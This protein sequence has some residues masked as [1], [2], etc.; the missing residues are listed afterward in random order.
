VGSRKLDLDLVGVTEVK[1]FLNVSRQRVHQLIRDHP[2]FPAPVAELASGRIWL[3][4]DIEEWARRVGRLERG[5]AAE[6][7]ARGGGRRL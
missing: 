4:K 1:E 7:R 2:D 3:R 5:G 6:S